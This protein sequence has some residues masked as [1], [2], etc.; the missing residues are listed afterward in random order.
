MSFIVAV[1]LLDTLG[2]AASVSDKPVNGVSSL[3]HHSEPTLE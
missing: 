3:S 2:S 1:L